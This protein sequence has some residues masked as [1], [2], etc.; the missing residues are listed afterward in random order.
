MR[1]FIRQKISNESDYAS[2]IHVPGMN[3]ELR[4]KK[5]FSIYYIIIYYLDKLERWACVNL[6]RF[7]RAKC[8]ILHLGWGNPHYQ[9]RLED[10]RIESS[11]A[12]RDLGVL[13]NERLDMSRQ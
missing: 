3:G 10:E 1:R 4:R 13:I 9:Y 7:N 12:E 8:K 2:C 5:S 11:P 6:L